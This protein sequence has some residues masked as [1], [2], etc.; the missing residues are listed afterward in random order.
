MKLAFK[1]ILALILSLFQ[2]KRLNWIQIPS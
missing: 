2:N 1:Q